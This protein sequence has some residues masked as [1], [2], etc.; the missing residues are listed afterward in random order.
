MT[1]MWSHSAHPKPQVIGRSDR[2][3]WTLILAAVSVLQDHREKLL[4]E[5]ANHERKQFE[6]RGF[7]RMLKWAGSRF[8]DPMRSL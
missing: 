1:P 4:H 6:R 2:D 3:N 5:P 7:S 8:H